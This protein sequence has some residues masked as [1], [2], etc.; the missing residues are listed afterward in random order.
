MYHFKFW[1]Q[2]FPKTKAKTLT[3]KLWK[4][5]GAEGLWMVAS[6]SNSRTPHTVKVFTNGRV[7]CDKGCPNYQAYSICA[8]CIGV[9]DQNGT[10]N[11]FVKW[12]RK[13]KR[14][15]NLTGTCLCF[16]LFHFASFC[17]V[18]CLLVCLPLYLNICRTVQRWFAFEKWKESKINRNQ[19]R[20]V[21]Q[22][23]QKQRHARESLVH[24]QTTV[25]QNNSL[26]TALQ[27]Q[28]GPCQHSVHFLLEICGF[29]TQRYPPVTVV[30][31]R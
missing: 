12:H 24:L 15:T 31:N 26:T 28:T 9:T 25:L 19:K 8:H 14:G 6:K 5:D 17:F 22:S 21:I 20:K 11:N 7:D 1:S 29:W 23:L 27:S 30:D 18:S 3:E 2:R 13:G 10:L 16:V 4:V